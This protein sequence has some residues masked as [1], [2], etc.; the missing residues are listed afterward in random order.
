MITSKEFLLPRTK[1][2]LGSIGN[3]AYAQETYNGTTFLETAYSTQHVRAICIPLIEFAKKRPLLY[4][5]CS[6][7]LL[8]HKI[9]SG[10][11][12]QVEKN[13]K[14]CFHTLTS[15]F[16]SARLAIT[17]A[18]RYSPKIPNTTKN[19]TKFLASKSTNLCWTLVKS[20]GFGATKK[21]PPNEDKWLQRQWRSPTV[22][23]GPTCIKIMG[24]NQLK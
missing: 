11:S 6:F 12:K 23:R 18:T 5:T 19:T 21:F 24:E 4:K 8:L 13:S 22:D 20:I 14:K 1:I 10:K 2:F 17:R 15:S 9:Y 3:Q 16:L 7:T